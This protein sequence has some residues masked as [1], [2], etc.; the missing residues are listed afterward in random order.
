MLHAETLCDGEQHTSLPNSAFSNVTLIAGNQ[1][2]SEYLY[3]GNWEMPQI[4]FPKRALLK[5]TSILL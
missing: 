1:P 3:H 2:W 5:I 4:T